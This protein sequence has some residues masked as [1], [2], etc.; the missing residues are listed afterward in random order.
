MVEN[1]VKCS[2]NIRSHYE[3]K[4]FNF[5]SHFV[6]LYTET[7]EAVAA[8]YNEGSFDPPR[9][10]E[11]RGDVDPNKCNALITDPN[12]PQN[13]TRKSETKGTRYSIRIKNSGKTRHQVFKHPSGM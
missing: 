2:S 10:T 6:A 3:L 9:L 12:T 4:G 5:E 13:W 7:R 8:L 11:M 1:L